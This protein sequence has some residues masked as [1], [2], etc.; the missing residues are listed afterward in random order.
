MY[1]ELRK[2]IKQYIS[3]RVKGDVCVCIYDDTLIIEIYNNKLCWRHTEQYISLLTSYP[4]TWDILAKAIIE[5]Y[6]T[7]IMSTKINFEKIKISVDN[8]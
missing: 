6:I 5:K 4:D 3:E 1:Y 8:Q 7:D 2:R